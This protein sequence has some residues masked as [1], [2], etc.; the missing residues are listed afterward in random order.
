MALERLEARIIREN[1]L[2][3]N[4]LFRKPIAPAPT[5]RK[6]SAKHS[7]QSEFIKWEANIN[8][9]SKSLPKPPKPAPE[10]KSKAT[11]TATA[12]KAT[13][14]I[15]TT[16]PIVIEPNG[17]NAVIEPN[18]TEA[19]VKKERKPENIG[20]KSK[21]FIVLEDNWAPD[22]HWNEMMCIP[23]LRKARGI[24]LPNHS[25]QTPTRYF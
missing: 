12:T 14:P 4:E 8:K 10:P 15:P 9:R 2:K 19:T 17:P 16:E 18:V 7:F 1:N 6:R 13:K 25:K 3:E 22:N 20:K 24:F 21:G 23:G 11:S 5:S